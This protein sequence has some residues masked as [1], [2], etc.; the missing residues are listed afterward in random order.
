MP[1]LPP[2][3][4]SANE[5]GNA[6]NVLNSRSFPASMILCKRNKHKAHS[7][8]FLP[9]SIIYILAFNNFLICT[10]QRPVCFYISHWSFVGAIEK[11]PIG[12]I[13]IYALFTTPTIKV[14]YHLP[15]LPLGIQIAAMMFVLCRSTRISGIR[16]VILKY[17]HTRLR[18]E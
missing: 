13:Q 6:P 2:R 7:R 5:S 8:S 14:P 16:T 3:I 12:N 18:K 11:I 17:P 4:D 9:S 10:G 1:G 15:L